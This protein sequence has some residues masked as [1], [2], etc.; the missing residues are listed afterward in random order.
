MTRRAAGTA[1]VGSW[2]VCM[3][4]LVL[5]Q[6][7]GPQE[8]YLGASTA[9]LAPA[10]AFYT[11][12]VDGH[13]IGNAGITLDTTFTGYRLSEVWNLD[14]LGR[15]RTD[16]H[17]YRSDATLSRAFKLR[18]QTVFL[19]EARTGRR[20]ELEW[21]DSSGNRDSV[22]AV[23]WHL[24]ERRM[25]VEELPPAGQPTTTGAVAFRLAADGRLR[26][27]G[28][29]SLVSAA[30]L[31]TVMHEE[32]ATVVRD[33]LFAISDSAVYDSTGAEWVP[34]IGAPIRAWQVERTVGT[35]PVV[36]WID[37]R[38]QLVQRQ[39]AFGATLARSPFEINYTQYLARLRAGELRPRSLPGTVPRATLTGAPDPRLERVV[40]RVSRSDG[41]A[42][43]GSGAAFRGGRQRVQGDTVTVL[44]WA[45][46]SGTPPGADYVRAGGQGKRRMRDA[47]AAAIAAAPRDTLAT[48]VHWVAAE[49]KLS[50]APTAGRIGSEAL[51]AGAGT[52]EGKVLLFVALARL[53]GLPA[54]AV[55][56]VDLS[57]LELPAHSWAEVWQRDR[58]VSVDPVFDQ[59]PASASLLRVTEGAAT[60]ITLVPLVASLR[61]TLLP[62]EP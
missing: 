59:V 52:V 50:D 27:G 23:V 38:G 24:P 31:L 20:L 5:R 61:A 22:L 18:S 17:V 48:L 28:T 4:W 13:P 53:A 29:L 45:D 14:L 43:P 34:V 46:A 11:V 55:S 41:P 47:L 12:V 8:A 21:G 30:P 26:A 51:R 7:T 15:E 19:T 3:G 16:R 25:A 1:I 10:A 2:V 9:R 39:W 44:R 49:V 33:S 6:F 58:W 32:H 60:A 37:G 36:D 54:R 42:W 40:V 35:M 62:P 57:R 56:G